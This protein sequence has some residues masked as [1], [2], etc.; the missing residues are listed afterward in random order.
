MQNRHHL[1]YRLQV[2]QTLSAAT[3][4]MDSQWDSQKMFEEA[5]EIKE[6]PTGECLK[7][8]PKKTRKLIFA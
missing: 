6:A 2:I 3:R 5:D 7:F 4:K 1:W 8:Y